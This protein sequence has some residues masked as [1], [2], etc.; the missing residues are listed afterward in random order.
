MSQN[1]ENFKRGCTE[2][3]A[4]YLLSKEDMY[5]YQMTTIMDETSE[6]RFTMLE[7][8]LYLILYRLVEAGYITTYTKLVGK[9]RTRRYY[10]L[11]EAGREYLKKITHEY[12][13][14]NL[15]IALLLD[16]NKE[17]NVIPLKKNT[18]VNE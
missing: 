16:R 14:V 1:T 9:K 15:G 13:E 12:D 11:E 5:G 8:S 6:G 2:L 7:G 4:L 17:T 10:H 18:T 3:V